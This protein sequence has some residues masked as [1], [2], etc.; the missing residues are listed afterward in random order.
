M[1]PW[2]HSTQVCC[3]LGKGAGS[4]GVKCAWHRHSHLPESPL[5]LALIQREQRVFRK[6]SNPT[7]NIYP[8]S[9]FSCDSQDARGPFKAACQF[10][11]M[12]KGIACTKVA[13]WSYCS[14][15]WRRMQVTAISSSICIPRKPRMLA[16]CPS[17]LGHAVLYSLSK[18]PLPARRRVQLT[19]PP[20]AVKEVPGKF[21]SRTTDEVSIIMNFR[22]QKNSGRFHWRSNSGQKAARIQYHQRILP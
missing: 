14:S 20:S 1:E 18:L 4:H 7:G 3:F 15:Y 9:R 6:L 10:Q 21:L 22:V 12:G 5:T 16:R 8:D 11:V 19:E 2:E 13:C 17:K